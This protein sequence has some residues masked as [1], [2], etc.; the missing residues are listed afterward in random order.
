MR[1]CRLRFR[2]HY[3]ANGNSGAFQ[4]LGGKRNDNVRRASTL[5]PSLD[6]KKKYKARLF[7]FVVVAATAVALVDFL[8]S[9]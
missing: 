3:I 5:S 7:F 4:Q 8:L 1:L 2:S 9:L 6:I